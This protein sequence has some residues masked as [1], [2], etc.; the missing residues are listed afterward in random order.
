MALVTNMNFNMDVFYNIIIAEIAAE[1]QQM[2]TGWQAASPIIWSSQQI[3]MLYRENIAPHRVTLIRINAKYKKITSIASYIQDTVPPIK[4]A[5]IIPKVNIG[6]F[7]VSN[8]RHIVRISFAFRDT[9]LYAKCRYERFR[10]L[11]MMTTFFE[12]GIRLQL[13]WT[14]GRQD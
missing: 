14:D 6:L 10:F 5:A 2:E 1:G 13:R 9:L 4:E 3:Q 7:A 11:M 12:I 8:I